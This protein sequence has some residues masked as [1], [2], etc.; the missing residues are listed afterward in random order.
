MRKRIKAENREARARGGG[1]AR[2]GDHSQVSPLHAFLFPGRAHSQQDLSS[3]TR[4]PSLALGLGGRVLTSGL[5]G[6]PVYAILRISNLQKSC[7]N[8]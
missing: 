7:E 2:E 5:P 3:P 1:G 8:E 6:V 4:D